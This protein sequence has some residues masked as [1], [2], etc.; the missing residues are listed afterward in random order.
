MTKEEII[1]EHHM[2][3]KGSVGKPHS[4]ADFTLEYAKQVA[5]GFAEWVEDNAEHWKD[6]WVLTTG[7]E[8][9]NTHYSTA[10]LYA[11][12]SQSLNSINL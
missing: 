11:L 8:A 1:M 3:Q 7:E 6:Y 9:D 2:I 5:I 4:H 10:E 12:Y